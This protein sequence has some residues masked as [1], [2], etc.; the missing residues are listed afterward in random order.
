MG[1]QTFAVDHDSD[2]NIVCDVDMAVS[3][4]ARSFDDSM[5]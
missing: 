5:T 3:F 4:G 2:M 1:G